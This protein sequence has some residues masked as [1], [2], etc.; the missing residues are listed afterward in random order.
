[1]G[2][3]YAPSPVSLPHSVA[4]F[5]PTELS[6]FNCSVNYLTLLDRFPTNAVE[7]GAWA[8]TREMP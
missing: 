7:R 5:Q 2:G 1:M 8:A 6:I 3:R 4:V